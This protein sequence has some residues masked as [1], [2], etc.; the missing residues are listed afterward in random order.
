MTD[1]K[2]AARFYLCGLSLN[3]HAIH[4]KTL[5]TTLFVN[6]GREDLLEKLGMEDVMAF[7]D[8]FDIIT[9]TQLPKS[10]LKY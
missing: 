9:R 5:L 3:P 7:A 2:N 1:Y 8:E 10:S 6:V 4:I